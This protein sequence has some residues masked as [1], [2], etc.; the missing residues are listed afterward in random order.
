VLFRS[1]ILENVGTLLL[2]WGENTALLTVVT[3]VFVVL[4]TF[5]IAF[6]A[7][8]DFVEYDTIDSSKLKQLRG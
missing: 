6:I 3:E 1:L 5:T 2:V 7:V 8:M 4:I